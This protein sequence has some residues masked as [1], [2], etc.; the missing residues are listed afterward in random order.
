MTYMSHA[1]LCHCSV[2]DP[3]LGRNLRTA[4]LSCV[5]G[6]RKAEWRGPVVTCHTT[7]LAKSL[8]S[9][10]SLDITAR[11]ISIANLVRI[12][13]LTQAE[14]RIRISHSEPL[15]IHRPK[16]KSIALVGK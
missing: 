4:R 15:R 5:G 16:V 1:C 8:E 14:P 6:L 11:P 13:G 7:A 12:V 9:S 3:L 2:S 10:L